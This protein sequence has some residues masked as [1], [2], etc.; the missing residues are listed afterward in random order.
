MGGHLK[1]PP[2][3][4]IFCRVNRAVNSA[5][6]GYSLSYTAEHGIRPFFTTLNQFWGIGYTDEKRY[7]NVSG[8]ITA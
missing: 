5:P 1:P 4:P 3:P 6:M 8:N 7:P 2:P